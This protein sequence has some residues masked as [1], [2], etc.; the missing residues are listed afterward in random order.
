MRE[1]R[2][3]GSEGG[4]V[5]RPSLPLCAPVRAHS[6][7]GSSPFRALAK[8]VAESN[9][10]LVKGGGEQLEAKTWSVGDE[11]DSA[12]DVGEPAE[13]WRNLHLSR[14]RG[15]SRAIAYRRRGH[16]RWLETE[17]VGGCAQ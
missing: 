10:V 13:D 4:A 5:E 6:Q 3:S 9:C 7:K 12:G 2:Q 17:R 11:L 16:S 1:I 14:D 8:P 15:P